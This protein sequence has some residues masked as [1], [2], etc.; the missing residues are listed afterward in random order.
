[1]IICLSED[2]YK[3]VISPEVGLNFK[4]KFMCQVPGLTEETLI[5][6]MKGY[7]INRDDKK[8]RIIQ[9]ILD[10][11]RIVRNIA[12]CTEIN[13]SVVWNRV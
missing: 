10:E 3:Q 7:K 1:M 2:A 8:V 4:D 12:V 6:K 11:N 9:P 13:D 5:K